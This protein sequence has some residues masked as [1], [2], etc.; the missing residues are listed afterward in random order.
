MGASVAMT[1]RPAFAQVGA[2]LGAPVTLIDRALEDRSAADIAKDN[3]IVVKV[4]AVMAKAGTI[5][6]ST[7]I[8]EQRLLVT[9]LF[10][11]KPTYDKF[12][13]GV[14]GVGGVKRL[15][16]HV[17]YMSDAD[18][19]AHKNGIISWA[20]ALEINSKAEAALAKAKDVHHLNYRL[21]T[22]A[23]A[24]LYVVGRA[25][26]AHERDLTL[27]SLKSIGGVRRVVDYIDVRPKAK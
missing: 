19:K 20:R 18:Q 10:D 2:I 5:K 25:L 23:F 16:W 8:Y 4:N 15:Y 22:D 7:E 12:E 27:A 21:A 6:A 9:G 17:V 24:T 3:E 11:D 1:A 13:S 14:R 26:S